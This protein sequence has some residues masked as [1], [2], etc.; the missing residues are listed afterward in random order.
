[1]LKNLSP[2]IYPALYVCSV[3]LLACVTMKFKILEEPKLGRAWKFLSPMSEI[4]DLKKLFAPSTI[5][6]V[7]WFDDLLA[8]FQY[9][10]YFLHCNPMIVDATIIFARYLCRACCELENIRGS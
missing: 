4:V 6:V 8:I 3:V 1:V 5:A 2:I 9:H 10:D 7:H